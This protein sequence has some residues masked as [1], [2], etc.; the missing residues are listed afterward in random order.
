MSSGVTGSSIRKGKILFHI[1]ENGRSFDLD[2]DETTLVE[3]IMRRIE[4]LSGISFD[5]Q[6]FLYLDMNLESL[7]QLSAFKLPCDEGEVFIFNKT[8]LQKNSL[9]P[10]TEQVDNFAGRTSPSSSHNPHPLNEASNERLFRHSILKYEHCERLLRELMVQ[11]RAVEFARGYLDRDYR[12]INLNYGNFMKHYKRQH[13][14]HSDLLLNFERNVEKLKSTKLHPALQ[15]PTYKCLMDFVKEENLSKSVDICT[16]SHKQFEN[17]VSQFEHTFCEVKHR[18]QEFLSV[19]ASL[20]IKKLEQT[21]K[22]YQKYIDEQTS[23][24]QSL[25]KDVNTLKKLADDCLSSQLSLPLRPHDTVSA[26]D[27]MYNV[28]GKDHFPGM[29]T[30]DH[31]IS[32]LLEFCKERKN[33]MNIFVHNFMQNITFGYRLIKDQ[34]LQFPV[35]K[36]AMTVQN[37]LFKDLKLFHG[38]GPAYRACFAEVVRRKASS[39]L[40]KGMA[41][42]IAENLAKKREIE[43][44]KRV[45]FLRGHGS[46]IP[47]DVLNSMG[48]FDF[49]SK[50]DVNFVEPFDEDLLNIDIADVDRYA[51]EYLGEVSSALS[52]DGSELIE[53]SGSRRME[54]EIVKL[55]AEVSARIVLLCSLCPEVESESLDDDKVD[56]I[57]KTAAE[58]KAEALQLKDEYIK[59]TETMLRMKQMQCVSYETRIRKLEEETNQIKAINNK[60]RQE[61]QASKEKIS[62]GHLEVH[63]IAVFVLIASGHYQAITRDYSN[64]YLSTECVAMLADHLPCRPNH[65]FGQIVH[66]EHQ[67]VKAMPLISTQPEHARVDQPISDMET[68]RL[69]LNSGSS[70]NPY[71]L[72]IGCDYFVVTVAMLPDRTIHSPSPSRSCIEASGEQMFIL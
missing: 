5:D 64:Y 11:E 70:S 34:K 57:L 14:K 27:P 21:I 51:P 56:G 7:R 40:Y 10:T 24:M 71:G 28:H 46:C 48:L 65:I 2:C 49:F 69:S 66:I 31:D 47:D 72:P 38:V 52:T 6:V 41:G 45:E 37:D 62:F 42:Q 15:T 60:H 50:C 9:P 22:E 18:V 32:K 19:K 36:K 25:S 58:K 53:T 4:S 26:L 12:L 44:R 33:K 39:K 55:K 29:Q 3:E 43:T 13:R 16:N 61:K 54:V 30:C 68:D 35:F 8:R 17:K 59:L 1:A 67:V 63:E 20:S 23:I